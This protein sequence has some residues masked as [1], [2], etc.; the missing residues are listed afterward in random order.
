[1]VLKAR[2]TT[3]IWGWAT[4]MCCEARS[5]A[6][7]AALTSPAASAATDDAAWPI[8]WKILIHARRGLECLVGSGARRIDV[9]LV[10][11]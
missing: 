11:Q 8:P 3:A 10:C 4:P 9:T 5:L 1:M 7:W 6:S 2:C